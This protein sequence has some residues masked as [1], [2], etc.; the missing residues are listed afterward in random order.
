M[1]GYYIVCSD[2][3]LAHRI[4]YKHLQNLNRS[5]SRKRWKERIEIKNKKKQQQ[6]QQHT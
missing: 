6:Q 3:T 2:L 1:Y 5:S 4:Q